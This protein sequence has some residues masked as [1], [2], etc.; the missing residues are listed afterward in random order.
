M[1]RRNRVGRPDRGWGPPRSLICGC[2]VRGRPSLPDLDLCDGRHAGHEAALAIAH[3]ALAVESNLHRHTLDDLRVKLPVALSGG[4]S[5]NCAPLAGARLSTRDQ[6][7]PAGKGIHAQPHGLAGLQVGKLRL[8]EI[9]RH[10]DI[11]L[12]QR[13]QGLPR[14]DAIA[15]FEVL[16]PDAPGRRREYLGVGKL[17]LRLLEIA[18]ATFSCACA[19]A[20]SGAPPIAR[21]ASAARSA[22]CAASAPACAAS[23]SCRE[24][25]RC[26]AWKSALARSKSCFA[27]VAWACSRATCAR[28]CAI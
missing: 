2:R 14:L 16:L 19:A 13:Q 17:E 3:G 9:R 21:A 1:P 6:Q 11:R 28:A 10:P 5:A 18:W 15:G 4:S 20:A 27:L 7:R 12:D 24:M 23:N 22:A 26:R 25:A 8:F